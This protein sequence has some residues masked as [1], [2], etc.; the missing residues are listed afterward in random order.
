MNGEVSQKPVE[1]VGGEFL[2]MSP[3]KTKEPVHPAEI[4]LFGSDG[5]VV[6]PDRSPHVFEEPGGFGPLDGGGVGD[7]LH[8]VKQT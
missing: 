1:V 2:G 3:V 6:D 7:Y 5:V 4:G 8:G